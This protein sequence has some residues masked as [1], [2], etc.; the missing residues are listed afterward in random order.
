[1]PDSFTIV[2]VGLVRKQEDRIWIEIDPRYRSCMLGLEGFSHI[3][4]LYWFH[5]ND[6]S[7]GRRIMRVHPRKN[8]K[9]PL[10]GVFATHSPMRPN[11]IGLTR[12]KIRSIQD[13]V[14]EVEDL[15]A[16]DHSPVLDIKCYIPDEK[17]HGGFR[18]PDWV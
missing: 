17:N 12:C 9:N 8:Q 18:V 16:R 10:T 1:M 3:H 13:T 2:P 6:N 5:E 15:D 11:P 7:E 14:I 4:V